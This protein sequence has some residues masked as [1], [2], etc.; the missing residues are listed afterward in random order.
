MKQMR[1]IHLFCISFLLLRL[2]FYNKHDKV[3]NIRNK[4]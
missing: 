4:I 2:K 3:I 1:E